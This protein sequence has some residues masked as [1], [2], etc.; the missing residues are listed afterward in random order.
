MTEYLACLI[1]GEESNVY[2]GEQRVVKLLELFCGKENLIYDYIYG[3]DRTKELMDTEFEKGAYNRIFELR[4]QITTENERRYN[5]YQWIHKFGDEENVYQIQIDEITKENH[6]RINEI[7]D[8]FIK[9]AN[10][11]LEKTGDIREKL[12]FLVALK[13]QGKN[14]TG[15]SIEIRDLSKIELKKIIDNIFKIDKEELKNYEKILNEIRELDIEKD[16]NSPEISISRSDNS[17]SKTVG[18][19]IKDISRGETV[20]DVQAVTRGLSQDIREIKNPTQAKGV[21]K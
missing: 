8:I 12:N 18:E 19:S 17:T 10:I 14:E 13:K 16:S 9:M 6:N 21:E 20:R 11:K 1:N 4:D 5:L 3:T 15:N 7:N 2:Y